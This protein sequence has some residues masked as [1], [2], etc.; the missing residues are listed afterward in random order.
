M[1][2]LGVGFAIAVGLWVAGG[3]QQVV[4]PNLEIFGAQPDFLLV[5]LA[6]GALYLNRTQGAVLGFFC[7]LI[8][9][10]LAGANLTHYV[11][12][13]TVGGFL[14]G[15]SKRTALEPNAV[16]AMATGF[17]LT[18]ISRLLFMFL[19]APKELL[20]YL[21]ATIVT[22]AYNGVLVLPVY[23]L[24]RWLRGPQRG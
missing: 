13:R 17:F 16:F 14:A 10:G 22:A 6:G 23:F 20:P 4:A 19:A 5:S 18:V 1:K 3:F 21:G 7:G 11:I 8:H 2:R 9:G 12:S 24:L 15:W